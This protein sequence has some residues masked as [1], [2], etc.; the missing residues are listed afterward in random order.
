MKQVFL[1]AGLLILGAHLTS[2]QDKVI[3]WA[4]DSLTISTYYTVVRQIGN[5]LEGTLELKSSSG[6]IIYEIR[7]GFI[8][9]KFSYNLNGTKVE[10]KYFVNRKA[11][12][13]YSIWND[14]GVLLIGGQYQ[15][16]LEYGKWVFYY[17]DGQKQM[18]GN[19]LADSSNL[20]ERF[21]FELPIENDIEIRID[22]FQKLQHSSADGEWCIY[23]RSGRQ[24]Q[25]LVFKKGVLVGY[26]LAY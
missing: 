15:N 24:L 20:I 4:H 12:G 10:E 6:K 18:E 26:H 9:S 25:T 11:H 21:E 3:R 1:I 19:F 8:E 22:R 13:K 23:D 2:A 14:L 7:K 5:Q 16:G 17:N